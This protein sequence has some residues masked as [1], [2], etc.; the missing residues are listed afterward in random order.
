[1]CQRGKCDKRSGK[2]LCEHGDGCGLAK[3]RG[4]CKRRLD[5][6]EDGDG[7]MKV[8]VKKGEFKMQNVQLRQVTACSL[9]H[10]KPR[11]QEGW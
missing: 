2:D 3:E 6:D 7:K 9:T 8:E 1:L 11:L 4:E 5:V 10:L